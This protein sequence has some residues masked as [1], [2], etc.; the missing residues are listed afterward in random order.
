MGKSPRECIMFI[1]DEKGK[2]LR[3]P[4]VWKERNKYMYSPV[5]TRINK[6][7][8]LRTIKKASGVGNYT[9]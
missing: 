7:N 2:N 6:S 8:I 4:P 9:V 1:A 3:K 5:I